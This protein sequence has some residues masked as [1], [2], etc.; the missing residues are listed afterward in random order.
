MYPNGDSAT[1][2]SRVIAADMAAS[3]RA[4]EMMPK[5]AKVPRFQPSAHSSKRVGIRGRVARRVDE[6]AGE[7]DVAHGRR[8][9]AAVDLRKRASRSD[10]L[11]QYGRVERHR[12]SKTVLRSS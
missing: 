11:I 9:R 10:N 7:I 12:S 4:A 5:V 8:D 2:G 1:S 3:S 6:P